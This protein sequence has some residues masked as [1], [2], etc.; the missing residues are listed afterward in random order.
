MYTNI[1]YDFVA[2]TELA[3]I[4][5]EGEQPKIPRI[6]AYSGPDPERYLA[7]IQNNAQT[8]TSN[9]KRFGFVEIQR[10]NVRRAISHSEE[11]Q[12][13]FT[14]DS[15]SLI[16]EK[17]ELAESEIGQWLAKAHGLICLLISVKIKLITP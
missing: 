9:P 15:D 1:K 11:V 7:L 2:P 5:D 13:T 17:G 16:L 10:E 12:L 6:T 3:S 14:K 4:Y 8:Q